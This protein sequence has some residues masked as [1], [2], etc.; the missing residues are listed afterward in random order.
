MCEFSFYFSRNRRARKCYARSYVIF[1]YVILKLLFTTTVDTDFHRYNF[2]GAEKMPKIYKQM[3][4]NKNEMTNFFILVRTTN[5]PL[6]HNPHNLMYSKEF[7]KTF[8][9]EIINFYSYQF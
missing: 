2:V 8:L 5:V 4:L 9:L 7:E 6:F 1:R 3:K